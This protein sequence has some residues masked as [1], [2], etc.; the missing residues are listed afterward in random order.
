MAL[1]DT[2]T[3]T[4]PRHTGAD[5]ELDAMWQNEDVYLKEYAFGSVK[6]RNHFM[7]LADK[8]RLKRDREFADA[9]YVDCYQGVFARCNGE[10]SGELVF[11]LD[12]PNFLE[13]AE[14]FRALKCELWDLYCI[15][16]NCLLIPSAAITCEFSGSKGFHVT[17]VGSFLLF[18]K[19]QP[20]I[21]KKIATAI[22]TKCP[23]IDVSVYNER[24]LMRVKNSVNSKTGLYDIEIPIYAAVVTSRRHLVE[25][26]SHARKSQHRAKSM[27]VAERKAVR[28]RIEEMLSWAES[29][30]LY[31]NANK[32]SAAIP[33]FENVNIEEEMTREQAIEYV[34]Y[35]VDMRELVGEHAQYFDCVFHSDKTKSASIMPPTD[36]HPAWIYHCFSDNCEHDNLDNI[37][38][39]Q[40]MYNLDFNE[41][42]SLLCRMC[43]VVYQS[44]HSLKKIKSK[45]YRVLNDSNINKT[46]YNRTL[47]P[48]YQTFSSLAVKSAESL[49]M[50]SAGDDFVCVTSIRQIAKVAHVSEPEACRKMALLAALGFIKKFRDDEVPESVRGKFFE[51]CEERW[52]KDRTPQ[53]WSIVDL[54]NKKNLD[55]V[56]MMTR[57]WLKSGAKVKK[58]SYEYLKSIFGPLIAN[59]AYTKPGALPKFRYSLSESVAA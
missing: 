40:L 53:C 58:L 28:E 59:R 8:D 36:S 50:D 13:S 31:S 45:N 49:K 20:Q 39:A 54:S 52:G 38:V 33:T 22:K 11:D 43:G 56:L 2:V 55:Y 24:R 29:E 44:G 17:V 3:L 27:T 21:Y 1:I 15:L 19:N 9:G 34:K 5:A 23:H 35:A 12:E 7:T 10:Y 16:T 51:S 42:L 6:N 30:G 4:N 41:A 32:K 48:L 14:K 57:H 37:A 26:A 47:K 46:F 25:K 18:E